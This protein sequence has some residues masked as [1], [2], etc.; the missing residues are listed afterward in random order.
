MAED[1]AAEIQRF[2]VDTLCGGTPP[3]A[4]DADTDLVAA[5]VLDSMALVQVVGFLEERYRV[6][7][8]DADLEPKN[9]TTI[10]AIAAYV[11]R[12]KSIH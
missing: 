12:N 10:A 11:A 9:F 8:S 4:V 5:G 3:V 1:R 7:V 6:R 2:I